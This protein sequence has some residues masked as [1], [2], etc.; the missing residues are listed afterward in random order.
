[1]WFENKSEEFKERFVPFDGMCHFRM[2]AS[3]AKDSQGWGSWHQKLGQ[4]IWQ[5][6]HIR[7]RKSS[8]PPKTAP[9]RRRKRQAAK[10]AKDK[11]KET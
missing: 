11:D 7:G 1:M 9:A 3:I 4:R 2:P 5:R 8:L 6:R 10:V